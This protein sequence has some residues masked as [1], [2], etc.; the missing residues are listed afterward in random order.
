MDCVF[1]GI[2]SGIIPSRKIFDDDFSMA[3]L[4]IADDV[5]GHTLVI[6]KKHVNNLLDCDN[7]TL[8][9]LMDAAKLVSN[10][11][12][13]NCGYHGVNL[14]NANGA[15]AGQTVPHFHIHLIPRQDK[16]GIK[17]WPEFSGGKIPIDE[18]L[19]KLRI[20]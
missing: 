11:Y 19:A 16:D 2:V 20:E 15:A 3:F 8:T 10:H 6:P 9:H 14:L 17:A 4:D 12:V 5:D 13:E 7:E 1:C 18:M